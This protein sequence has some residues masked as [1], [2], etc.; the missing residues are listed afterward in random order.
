MQD[1]SQ[2]RHLPAHCDDILLSKARRRWEMAPHIPIALRSCSSRPSCA[3]LQ[4]LILSRL[5]TCWLKCLLA[6]GAPSRRLDRLCVPPE[7]AAAAAPFA[8][9][10]CLFAQ[11]RDC[12]FQRAR[13]LVVGAKKQ[14]S[15][16]Q[17]YLARLD[18]GCH[19]LAHSNVA[20]Q[21]CAGV[22]GL[23]I[24]PRQQTGVPG[25]T[26]TPRQQTPQ[27]QPQF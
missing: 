13:V 8:A 17:P 26:I 14:P 21:M 2:A 19:N 3:K 1:R 11:V 15:L 27:M 7:A 16:L 4:H 9:L 24:T 25:L 23:T 20:F 18:H 10:F 22:P 12:P 6:R 5:R